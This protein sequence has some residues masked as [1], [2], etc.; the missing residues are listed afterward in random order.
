MWD[1]DGD[2]GQS[3][4]VPEPH[5]HRQERSGGGDVTRGADSRRPEPV[6]GFTRRDWRGELRSWSAGSSGQ[7]RENA[8]CATDTRSRVS[9]EMF[10]RFQLLQ[11]STPAW[12]WMSSETGE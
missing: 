9:G 2:E 5:A 6:S 1:G 7:G 8:A 10:L 12:L 3:P 4:G 11:Q